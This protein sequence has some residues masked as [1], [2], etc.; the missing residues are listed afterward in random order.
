MANESSMVIAGQRDNASIMERVLIAG[1]LS[2]LTAAERNTYYNK[3]CESV[4]LNP[5]TRP[6]GYINLNGKMALYCLKDATEQLRKI[7]GVSIKIVS[8]EVVNDCYVIIVQATDR[9][10]RVDEAIGAVPIARLTGEDLSNAFMKCET[11]AKRRVTLSICGLGWTDESEV[12]SI[13][14]AQVIPAD[15]IEVS[16][17]QSIDQQTTFSVVLADIGACPDFDTL[18]QILTRVNNDLKSGKLP[19][20]KRAEINEAYSK[21]KAE[22]EADAAQ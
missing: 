3:V 20:G 8:R 14:G 19:K 13:A 9:D 7:H 11:K 21:R 16:L 10:G 4:G 17:T 1:D 5:L 18:K 12:S 6:F 22:L 2:K 15:D